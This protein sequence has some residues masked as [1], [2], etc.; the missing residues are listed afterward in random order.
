[1]EMYK[2]DNDPLLRRLRSD[3]R[4]PVPEEV[5]SLMNDIS[6]VCAHKRINHIVCALWLTLLRVIVHA[7]KCTPEQAIKHACAT[8][9]LAKTKAPDTRDEASIR[10]LL[11][12]R[13]TAVVLCGIQY[14][15]TL[16]LAR[17]ANLMYANK[18]GTSHNS[19]CRSLFIYQSAAELPQSK[20]SEAWR[21]ILLDP[22]GGWSYP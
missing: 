2:P 8:L 9:G 10:P 14:A 5:A 20:W 13:R 11:Y 19:S 1:M 15:E 7:Q 3:V 21:F 22:Q 17:I 6:D 4:A 18:H 16:L 12:T